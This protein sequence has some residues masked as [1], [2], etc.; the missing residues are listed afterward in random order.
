VQYTIASGPDSQTSASTDT[1]AQQTL[2]YAPSALW[3]LDDQGA[4]ANDVS[5]NGNNGTYVGAYTQG[6]SGPL[7]SAPSVTATSFG[8]GW[9]SLPAG[10]LQGTTE[11]LEA[12]FRT[13]SSGVVLGYQST[14]AGGRPGNYVPAFYVGTD[15]LLRAEVW[16]GTISP[17][18]SS[19]AVN[20]G[21]WQF[22][23]LVVSPSSQSL[24]L[25]GALV[26]TLAGSIQPLDMTYDQ[27]GWGFDY[28]WPAASASGSDPFTGTVGQVAIFP[29]DLTQS[30]LS[31]QYS[32]AGY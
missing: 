26:G 20:N 8:G 19:S 11:T 1:Y 21:Q 4:I 17:I 14:A 9:V 16:N 10:M 30:Q 15:G 12:W 24:Y 13:T 3:P 5:G 7:L 27:V 23:A 22:A 28:S 25:N 31:A 6:A 2:A 32:T 29:S 18:T